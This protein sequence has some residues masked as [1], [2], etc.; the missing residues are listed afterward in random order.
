MKERITQGF[1]KAKH[2]TQKAKDN[3]GLRIHSARMNLREN[4]GI[5]TIE[6]ILVLVVLIALVLIFKDQLL[7][8]IEN[9]FGRVVSDSSSI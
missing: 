8:L 9:I 6:V 2:V 3:V 4:R 7:S 1:T 5:S